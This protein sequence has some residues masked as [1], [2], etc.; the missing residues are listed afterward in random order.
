MKSVLFI[1]NGMCKGGAQQITADLA[2]QPCDRY[3]VSVPN[4]ALLE[5]VMTGI[6][7]IPQKAGGSAEIIK[8]MGNGILS[9]TGERGRLTAAMLLPAEDDSLRK[10]LEENAV[11][12]AVNFGIEYSTA[13]WEA[14]L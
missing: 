11:R 6:A 2:D 7:C 14:L 13:Q 12:T 3:D 4:N 9:D 8:S 1:I 5:A 10:K